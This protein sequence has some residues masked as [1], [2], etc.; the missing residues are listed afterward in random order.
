MQGKVAAQ[1]LVEHVGGI[2]RDVTGEQWGAVIDGAFLEVGR[3]EAVAAD[4]V[5]VGLALGVV[6]EGDC[7]GY[8]DFGADAVFDD[9]AQA[10]IP[11]GVLDGDELYV[12]GVDAEAPGEV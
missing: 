3:D 7:T 11:A 5:A 1:V 12:R 8:E 9:D 10:A 6:E 4:V 2:R